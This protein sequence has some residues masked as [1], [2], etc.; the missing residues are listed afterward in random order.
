[1]LRAGGATVDFEPH[2]QGEGGTICYSI[3][4]SSLSLPWTLWDCSWRRLW[5][6]GGCRLRGGFHRG[7]GGPSHSRSHRSGRCT[8]VVNSVCS[9][10]GT[11]GVRS[12]CL[13]HP[14]SHSAHG[15]IEL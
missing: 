5:R 12:P 2:Q 8:C 14:R 10:R 6:N 1:M 4:V 11:G 9:R 7:K 15:V 3:H 13:H